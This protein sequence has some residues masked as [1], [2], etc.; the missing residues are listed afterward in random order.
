M[1]HVA[2]RR[3]PMPTHFADAPHFADFTRAFFHAAIDIFAA[4]AGH[5]ADYA[6]QLSAGWPRLRY[7][8]FFEAAIALR[9]SS[10]DA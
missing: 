8:S 10:Y 5:Y 3:Q 2:E 9:F 1:R 7:V 4:T 6:S